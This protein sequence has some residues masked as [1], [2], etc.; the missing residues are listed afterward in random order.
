MPTPKADWTAWDDLDIRE[1]ALDELQNPSGAYD[2]TI[3]RAGHQF[4]HLFRDAGSPEGSNMPRPFRPRNASDQE[5]A[6][7]NGNNNNG[8][9]LS[10]LNPRGRDQENGPPDAETCA[11]FIQM[12]LSG[13]ATS[14]AENETFRA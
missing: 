9:R 2:G 4:D 6:R 7:R 10:D 14:D 11:S 8:T 1:L 3:G 5:F 12:L 13:L